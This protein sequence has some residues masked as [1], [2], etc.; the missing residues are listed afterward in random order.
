MCGIVGYVGDKE[1]APIIL[2]GLKRLEYRGYD[3]AGIAI[4]DGSHITLRKSMGR[5]VKLEEAIRHEMPKGSCG[6]G[7]TR[8]A[9]HGKP[10]DLNAHPHSDC[11]GEIV[12]VHNGIFEN[13]SEVRDMLV[14]EGHVMSSETDTEVL[15]HLIESNYADDLA[16]AVRESLKQVRGSYAIVVMS[17]REPGKLV[18]ARKDSPLIAGF[19]EG[20][21]FLASDIPALLPHTRQM[22]VVNDGEVVELDKKQIRFTKL[23]G[24]PVEKKPMTVNWNIEAAEKGGY[25][26]FML[27]EI[28]EQPRAIRETLSGRIAPDGRY[29]NVQELAISDDYNRQL[30]RVQ[31]IACGTA[32]YACQVGRYYIEK[33]AGLPASVEVGSEFRYSG[34]IMGPETLVVAVSQSGETADTLA[35][36]REAKSHGC[37]VVAITNVVGSSVSR[38]ADMVMYTYAGPEIAVASTKAYLTQIEALCL[39]G[40]DLGQRRGYID[41]DRVMSVAGE[42]K[43]MSAKIETIFRKNESWIEGFANENHEMPQAF[44]IGR[45]LDFATSLEGALKLKEISYVHAEAY[46]AGELKHGTLALVTEGTLVVALVTQPSLREKM[47]SN[48]QEVKARGAFVLAIAPE[49][50]AELSKHVDEAVYVPRTVPELMPILA[51]VP[52]QLFAY[53]MAVARGNDVDK[54][55]NLAKSVTVE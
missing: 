29:V 14:A 24:T 10:S 16:T 49:G 5:L 41:R 47:L 9:T 17:E 28:H 35:A 11:T 26:H 38:E 40:L 31:L 4:C 27:K 18:A 20:E 55:R 50:D 1:A 37:K 6:M 3:S 48:I 15:A 12:M 30:R 33:F 22:C 45:G 7:H 51:V 13:Y 39:L 53:Y 21:N 19:G 8:W 52:L 54:P 42:L 2:D 25:R 36:I 46:A 32:S 34:P 44:F 23:D 43:E